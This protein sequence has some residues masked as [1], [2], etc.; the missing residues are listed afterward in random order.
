[1]R[2]YAYRLYPFL[3]LRPEVID[4]AKFTIHYYSISD[5]HLRYSL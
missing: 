3:S 4:E 2:Q 1:M 5:S